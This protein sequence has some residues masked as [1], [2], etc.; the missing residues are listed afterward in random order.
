[1][2]SQLQ[3]VL[4]CIALGFG[5]TAR[6]GAQSPPAIDIPALVGGARLGAGYAQM[7]GIAAVPGIRSANYNIDSQAGSP[8]LDVVRV[9]YEHRWTRLSDNA[10][11]YW[12][13]SGGYMRFKDDLPI[14]AF[15]PDDGSIASRWTGYSGSAGVLAKVRLGQGFKLEPAI[16]FALARLENSASYSGTATALQPSFD[17]L[18]FNWDM[19]AWLVTPSIAL[20]WA[21]RVYDGE[22]ITRGRVAR[23]WISSFD[24]SDP[25]LAFNQ[26]V[27]IF[28]ISADYTRATSLHLFDRQVSWVARGGYFGFFGADRDALGFDQVA[29]VGGGFEIPIAARTAK[30]ERLR[31][32]GA[33]L[34]GPDVD[35]WSGG[36]SMRF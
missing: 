24:E 2:S 18:L 7:V 14:S 32:V 11:L 35:G 36:L 21:T 26:A 6:A 31:L 8:T 17:G 29:E 27:N 23:S 34:F 33:Y 20:E 10:D 28:S 5:M 9:P 12:T 22:L 16:D 19:N 4:L 1:M 30:G 15:A 13:V 25:V 3:R